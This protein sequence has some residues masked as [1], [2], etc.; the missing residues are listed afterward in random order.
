MS[1][2]IERVDGHVGAGAGEARAYARPSYEQE[3][4]L[5]IVTSDHGG[6]GTGHNNGHNVPEIL[7]SFL[8]V[9]GAAAGRVASSNDT[10]YLVDV[11]PTAL[12]HLGIEPAEEWGLDGH[13]VGL[14]A[15]ETA[16]P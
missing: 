10:T 2:A 12:A 15:T 9:S 3:D 6:Q 1:Q 8:I 13:A 11:V 7:N 14:V 4:W 5:V 16:E